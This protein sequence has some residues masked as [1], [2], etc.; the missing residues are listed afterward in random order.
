MEESN[1]GEEKKGGVKDVK[2]L[3]EKIVNGIENGI[4]TSKFKV[5]NECSGVERRGLDIKENQFG[6]FSFSIEKIL[7]SGNIKIIEVNYSES[8]KRDNILFYSVLS[9]DYGM[10][11][12]IEMLLNLHKI[13]FI[14][15]ED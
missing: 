10:L 9:C 14:K 13:N 2:S 7:S 1:V 8:P 5:V 4:G 12:L 6:R 11:T 15:R 3:L